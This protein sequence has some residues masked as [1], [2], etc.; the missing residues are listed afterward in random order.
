M[1]WS[2]DWYHLAADGKATGPT[3]A[4]RREQDSSLAATGREPFTSS[5]GTMTRCREQ[6]KR[7][8]ANVSFGAAEQ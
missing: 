2:C 3:E 8:L 4:V 5:L 1:P 6:I 7:Q